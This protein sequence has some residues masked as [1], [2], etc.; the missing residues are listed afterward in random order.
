MSVAT[1]NGLIVNA[2]AIYGASSWQS[3]LDNLNDL[4]H[5]AE[6]SIV[7]ATEMGGY[8][9]GE[10]LSRAFGWGG[11]YGKSFILH[12]GSSPINTAI[13]Y[14]P[15]K[16][17]MH[18]D[19][20]NTETR[21]FITKSGTTHR[22]A[23]AVLLERLG[24]GQ[25]ILNGCT[26]TQYKPHGRNTIPQYDRE[27]YGQMDGFLT[28]LDRWAEQFEDEYKQASIAR[29]GCGDFNSRYRT[30]P[31][32]HTIGV[33]KAM[34]D[35]GYR[36]F[37][38]AAEQKSGKPANIIDRGCYKGKVRVRRHDVL[39]DRGATDHDNGAGVLLSVG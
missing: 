25:F 11:K 30:D 1:F 34:V 3:R 23:S 27:R 29:L 33:T 15:A 36:D 38:I 19:I 20:G 8:K 13:L 26:H 17:K 21:P 9:H 22:W 28:K 6:A 4:R 18:E 5:R 32:C 31:Y 10:Q 39:P 24:T 12:G 35:N 2:W 14:D 16:W 37:R 7:W